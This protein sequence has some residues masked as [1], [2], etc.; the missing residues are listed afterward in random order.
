MAMM[1]AHGGTPRTDAGGSRVES[2][3]R[4][5]RRVELPSWSCPPN[6]PPGT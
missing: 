3:Q 6:R 5:L 4:K 1:E 2:E